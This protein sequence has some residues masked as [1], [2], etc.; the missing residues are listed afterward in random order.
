MRWSRHIPGIRSARS[1][2]SQTS[3]TDARRRSESW[4]AVRPQS[5]RPMA[6]SS[7]S[8]DR[9]RNRWTSSGRAAHACGSKSYSGGSWSP[10]GRSASIRRLSVQLVNL[11]SRF[12]SYLKTIFF[13]RQRARRVRVEGA[14]RIFGL[15]EVE[16]HL[17]VDRSRRVEEASRRV[18][19]VPT[20]QIPKDEPQ[21]V[22]VF[23]DSGHMHRL[24]TE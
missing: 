7:T 3:G 22:L 2:V 14:G 5:D 1:F 10:D 20:G 11:L 16:R 15:V 12:D 21:L 8:P 17:P 18:G 9:P 23:G 24:A 19:F 13:R 6:S 4:T